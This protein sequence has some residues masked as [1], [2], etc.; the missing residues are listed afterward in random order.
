M[1]DQ[2]V[3]LVTGVAGYWG[4]R[5]ASQLLAQPG[6]HVIGLDEE[7]PEEEVKGLDFIQAS[8]HNPLLVDLLKQEAVEAVVHLAFTESIRPSETAFDVNVMGTMKLLGACAE[9]GVRKVV[10]KSSTLV[11]GAQSGNSAFLREDAPLQGSKGYGYIRDLVEIEAFCNGF[12]RQSPDTL[13]TVLRFAHIVGPRTDTPMTRFL[14]EEEALVLLGFDPMIQVIHE[15]DVVG[16]LVHAVIHDVPGVFNV[17][18]DRAMPLWRVMGLAGKLAAPVLHWL[19]YTS[20][21]LL[22]PRYAPIDLDYLRYPCVGDLHRMRTALKFVPQYTAEEALREFASQQRLRRYLPESMARAYDEERLRD[23]LE[24]RR[25]ARSIEAPREEQAQRRGRGRR[26]SAATGGAAAR[27][28]GRN[29][30]GQ[31]EPL[32]GQPI[33]AMEAVEENSTHG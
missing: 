15:D 13:M 20:V 1:P 14:R 4:G 9:A 31:T 10:V 29:V 6:L 27:R 23:T 26:A 3:V 25:R 11:Y 32:P 24:R 21:S 7:P 33:V 5:T 12:L 17:A 28:R 8:I 16:A 22:G 18:A 30:Q 19:A 2:R